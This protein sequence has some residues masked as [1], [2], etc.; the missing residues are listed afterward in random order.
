MNKREL[1]G[2]AAESVKSETL[3]CFDVGYDLRQTPA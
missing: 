2:K 3:R 1:E